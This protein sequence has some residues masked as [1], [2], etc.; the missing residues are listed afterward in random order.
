MQE[1]STAAQYGI[2]VVLVVFNNGAFGNV[3]RDQ[4]AL[5]GG[6]LIG[7]DLLP[8]LDFVRIAE[9][10]GVAGRRVTSPPEL[11]AVLEKA[12]AADAPYLIEVPVARGAEAKL[13]E[14]VTPKPAARAADAVTLETFLADQL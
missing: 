6:R 2:G 9:A 1:L 8:V 5:F 13:R 14:F 10:F 4:A 12:L 7:S 11:R 3:R